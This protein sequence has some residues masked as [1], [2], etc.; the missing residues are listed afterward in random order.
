MATN[1]QITQQTLKSMQ[2][3]LA[4]PVPWVGNTTAVA[5]NTRVLNNYES[6]YSGNAEAIAVKK[7]KVTKGMTSFKEVTTAV[8]SNLEGGYYHPNMLVDGRVKDNRY[9]ASGETM[10]GLDRKA[11]GKAINSCEPCKKFWGELDRVDA[12]HKWKWNYIPPDPLRSQLFIYASEIMEPL[13]N[14]SLNR[15]VK[16]KDLQNLIKSDGRL[17]FNFVYAQWN[18]PGWFQGFAREITKAYDSGIKDAEKLAALFVRLRKNNVG[19]IQ[20]SK[21]NSLIA[22]GGGKISEVVGLA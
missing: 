5:D 1:K 16:N 22:Q 19:V 13:F 3:A 14:D 9:G 15:Y 21:N 17:Y 6:V 8:I 20:N 4:N 12:S 10:F 2:E 11:G 7:G 18:G